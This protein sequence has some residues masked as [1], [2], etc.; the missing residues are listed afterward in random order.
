[1]EACCKTLVKEERERLFNSGRD[2]D[3]RVEQPDGE[4]A[5]APSDSGTT[6]A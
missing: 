2:F 3:L 1:M 5:A 6:G 4:E